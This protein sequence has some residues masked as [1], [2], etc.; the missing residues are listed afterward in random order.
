MGRNTW[1]RGRLALASSL[2]LIAAAAPVV[3]RPSATAP[4]TIEGVLV[5][6]HC[7]SL[8]PA[9]RATDHETA[10]GTIEACAQGCAKLGIPVGLL[11]ASGEVAVLIAPSH[12]FES[13]MGRTARATGVRVF[14]CAAIRPDSIS[15]KGTDGRWIKLELHHMM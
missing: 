1:N 5:D 9:Y 11:T 13:H 7:Y 12:D 2:L 6:T 14:G 4:V 3:P 8:D 15:V 10:D